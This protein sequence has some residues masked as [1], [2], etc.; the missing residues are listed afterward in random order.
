M[1][2]EDDLIIE[3]DGSEETGGS[4][5]D[6]EAVESRVGAKTDK[7]KKELDQVKKERQE[8]LDGWQRA[9]AD[10]VNALKRFEAEKVQAIELGKIVSVRAF[11]PVMDS[12]E[13]AEASGEVPESFKGIAKQL[14]EAAA[15]LGL[16]KF[17]AVGEAFNPMLHEA[18][19]QDATEEEG[20]DDSVSAVLEAGWKS[21][22][23]VIRPA[24]VR[25]YHFEG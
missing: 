5:E 13:R 14:H 2:R 19:G 21:K 15:L 9:K 24:K 10:Y 12:L 6:L 7:M 8:Y 1:D 20:K 4:E 3:S 16:E 11:I 17:G 23:A 18:L 25:V 22:E